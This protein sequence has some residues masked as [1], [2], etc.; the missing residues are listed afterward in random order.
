[1]PRGKTVLCVCIFVGEEG[2]NGEQKH[3]INISSTVEART[4]SRWM[5]KSVFISLSHV[6]AVGSGRKEKTF[7]AIFLPFFGG[8]N[9][10]HSYWDLF[11]RESKMRIR[12]QV[13]GTVPC[14]SQVRL[15]LLAASS[16][17]SCM[18][19]CHDYTQQLIQLLLE[20]KTFARE[21][22]AQFPRISRCTRL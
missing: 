7:V 5:R 10:W 12:K 19:Q 13:D 6:N 15:Q 18:G 22:L 11:M 4:S 14:A 2:Y 17:C 1:M 9:F 21:P 8:G 3:N 16:T 20:C